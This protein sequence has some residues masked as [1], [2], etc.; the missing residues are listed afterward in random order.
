MTQTTGCVPVN[1]AKL[2][3]SYAASRWSDDMQKQILLAFLADNCQ[4]TAFKQFLAEIV[5]EENRRTLAEPVSPAV[6]H[7]QGRFDT[8]LITGIMD[9]LSRITDIQVQTV[10]AVINIDARVHDDSYSQIVNWLASD[11]PLP[12]FGIDGE[13]IF[14]YLVQVAPFDII[15]ALT[16]SPH[17]PWIDAWVQTEATG[18]EPSPPP[19]GT[20]G[21]PIV[22][23]RPQGNIVLRIQGP[24]S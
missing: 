11:R 7:I 16:N 13:I 22:F 1:V 19:T 2:F 9:R 12:G 15:V 17:G 21:Q 3:A 6:R 8:S 20:L 10:A 4:P 5:N 24:A 18:I 23:E 14:G